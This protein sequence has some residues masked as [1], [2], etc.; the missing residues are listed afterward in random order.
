MIFSHRTLILIILGTMSTGNDSI[1]QFP[2]IQ[3]RQGGNHDTSF[4]DLMNSGLGT[5][6]SSAGGAGR[7]W[8]STDPGG[9]FSDLLNA[10][11]FDKMDDE[12]LGR[13][14]DSL[15]RS[16]STDHHQSKE[17]K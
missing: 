5:S 16:R 3:H 15:S 10:Q 2:S 8:Y 9:G 7:S 17:Y 1:S 12:Q 14:I 13:V 11:N 6:P 4:T